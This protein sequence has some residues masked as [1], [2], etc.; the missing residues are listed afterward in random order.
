MGNETGQG[1][2]WRI[3]GYQRMRNFWNIWLLLIL[4]LISS[5]FLYNSNVYA[6]TSREGLTVSPLRKEIDI[7]P[8]TSLDGT[9]TVINSTDKSIK[10]NLS[11][12]EFSVINQQYDYAFTAESDATKWVTFNNAEIDLT[13]GESKKVKYSVGVPLSAEPGG[14]YVSL[15]TSTDVKSSDENVNS[16]QRIA[17]LLYITVLGDVTRSGHLVS[18]TSPWMAGGKSIWSAALQNTGTTHFRSRYNVQIQNLFGH[19]MVVSKLGDAL[20]LPGTVRLVTDELPLP[21][22]PGLYK[23]VYTI[24]LGDTPAKVET[25]FILYLPPIVVVIIM[26]AIIILGARFSLKKSN[27]H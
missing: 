14:W 4:G 3:M 22:L 19:S 6:E 11:A 17:S 13:A 1:L 16:R 27:K 25:R 10:V 8:G 2:G 12:E 18:L 9:L 5:T 23:I 20:I 26:A 7:T 15:F 24:G 21:Q